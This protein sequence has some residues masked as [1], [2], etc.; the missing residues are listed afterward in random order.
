MC[1]I[2]LPQ[3]MQVLAALV[4]HVK[5]IPLMTYRYNFP[6][7]L[8]QTGGQDATTDVG[9]S[10]TLR[11]GQ[12]LLAHA[13]LRDRTGNNWR[14]SDTSSNLNVDHM[15]ITSYFWDVPSAPLSLHSLCM[16]GKPW[17][18]VDRYL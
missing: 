10:C 8:S 14:L 13:M 12:M 2:N 5:S 16:Y 17:G 6:P 15:S 3:D 18:Y 1:Y 7:I 9:W 4:L 11:S